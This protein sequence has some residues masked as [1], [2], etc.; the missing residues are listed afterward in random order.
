M[1]GKELDFNISSFMENKR[2]H[3]LVFLGIFVLASV[4]F[5]VTMLILESRNKTA[6]KILDETF[7]PQYK[8][9]IGEGDISEEESGAFID[10][11]KEFAGKYS[12]YPAAKAL[13]LAADIYYKR[14]DWKGAEEAYLKS[15]LKAEKSYLAPVSYFNAASAA[16]EDGNTDAAIE[17]YTKA[18]SYPD[19]S[20]ASHAQFSVG[21]LYESQDKIDLAKTAYQNVIDTWP[22]DTNWTA[23]AHSRLIALELLNQ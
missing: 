5:I 14:S 8:T 17:Y 7:M 18:F 21:R 23:L 16:E 10:E 19:F 13:S 12:G 3:I 1:A 4:G 9:L 20:Q 6:I 22:K 11:I 15:A 2:R